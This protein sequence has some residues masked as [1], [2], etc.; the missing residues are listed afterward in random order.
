MTKNDHI[1]LSL[2]KEKAIKQIFFKRLLAKSIMIAEFITG[3][4]WAVFSWFVFFSG[5]WLLNIHQA[6]G[7]KGAIVLWLLFI[8]GIVYLFLKRPQDNKL[9]SVHN[10]DRRLESDSSIEHRPLEAINDQIATH[11][12]ASSNKLWIQSK[13][14]AYARIKSIK[15]PRPKAIVT[16]YDRYAFRFGAL[17]TLIVGLIFAGSSSTERLMSGLFPFY[18]SGSASTIKTASLTIIPPD[19]TNLAAINIVPESIP[20]KVIPVPEGSTIKVKITDGFSTPR[21]HI[22]E[23]KFSLSDLG[24]KSWS[25]EDEIA[26][27]DTNL[28][29]TDQEQKTDEYDYIKIKQ[30]PRTLMEVP[31]IYVQD[32]PPT[33]KQDGEIDIDDKGKINIPLIAQDDYGIIE[34]K[35]R[36]ELDSIIEQTLRGNEFEQSRPIFSAPGQEF[37]FDSDYD[38]AW[39]P[40]AGLPVKIHIEVIDHNKQIAKLPVINMNLPERSFTHP[41]AKELIDIRQQLIWQD[42]EMNLERAQRIADFTAYPDL[43]ENDPVT[44]LALQVASSRLQ[45]QNDENDIVTLIELLWDI[46][47]RL[48]DGNIAQAAQN[49]EIAQQNLQDLLADPNASDEQIARA[50]NDLRNAMAAYMLEAFKEYQKELTKQG[51]Q[52][53]LPIEMFEN[54]MNPQDLDSFLDQLLSKAL[55]GDKQSA[56][57]MLSELE[58]FMNQFGD[59]NNFEL[60]EQTKF[61][62]K[63]ISDLQRLIEQQE[64]LL[65]QTIEQSRLAGHSSAVQHLPEFVLPK[66]DNTNKRH[67]MDI[68]DEWDVPAP[69][70]SKEALEA[71]DDEDEDKNVIDTSLHKGEQDA[72]RYALGQLMLEADEKL[73]EIPQSMQNAEKEMRFSA[74]ALGENEPRISIPHQE[75]AIEYLKEAMNQ[76][77]EELQRS[78]QNMALFSFGGQR[79]DP[80]GRP[81]DDTG[82]QGGGKNHNSSVNVPDQAERKRIQDILNTL[83]NKSGEFDRPEYELDYYRRL[84]QQF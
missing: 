49:L 37:K 14:E 53:D 40:W 58:N 21:L 5:L 78:L 28:V 66:N 44:V 82:E 76:M 71:E 56:Q 30:W 17:M 80:L 81:M 19:Y 26:Y 29:I 20:D 41:I 67:Q 39:H 61:Q 4:L 51:H 50:M 77:S 70:R 75:K 63:G 35:V 36:V 15:M 16:G 59:M 64:K 68:L 31:F 38:L 18:I 32:Q 33:I 74:N 46:A 47:I 60:S 1:Q 65:Q 8:S 84:M 11:R 42:S 45:Y 24:S 3:S 72:L 12:S 79:L 43:L 57:E 52:G 2:T 69:S 27:Q 13:L 73:G 62:M 9:P 25:Y 6:L 23:A 48:E 10:I 83:R 55:T 22:G 34:T 7:E 54:M